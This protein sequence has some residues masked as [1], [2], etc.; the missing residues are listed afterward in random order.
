MADAI[1]P[2]TTLYVNNLNDKINKEEIRSQLYALFTT[3]GKLIDVVATKTPKMRGQAFLVFNDLTSATAALRA[4]DGMVFYDKPLVCPLWFALFFH[5]TPVNSK[6]ISYAKSKSYAT[7]RREDPNFILPSFA[8]ASSAKRVREAEE[9]NVRAK[10]EKAGDEDGEEMDIEDDDE[11]GPAAPSASNS[12]SC[13]CYI[14]LRN[15]GMSGFPFSTSAAVQQIAL[16]KPS[17]GDHQWCLGSFVPT[18][19]G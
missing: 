13:P 10:R 1:Q 16:L 11:S 17:A 5:S 8:H 7:L 6:H 19:R 3:Y 14:P 4:C 12:M 15:N 18:V 9:L 2:N